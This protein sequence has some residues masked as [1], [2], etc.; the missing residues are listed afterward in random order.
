MVD[1]HILV[2]YA[3]QV[4]IKSTACSFYM[5]LDMLIYD[6]VYVS[7]CKVLGREQVTTIV[8]LNCR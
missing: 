1:E 6:H 7:V 2:C 8:R 4:N 5:V 3:I